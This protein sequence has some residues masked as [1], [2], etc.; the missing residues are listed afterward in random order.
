ML[1]MLFYTIDDT[2]CVRVLEL[3]FVFIHVW[4]LIAFCQPIIKNDDDDDD[5]TLTELSQ[6]SGYHC[7]YLQQPV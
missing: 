2:R 5:E 1:I 4:C 6:S 7:T 3:T